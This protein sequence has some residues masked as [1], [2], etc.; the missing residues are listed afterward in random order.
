MSVITAPAN[1][2]G[3]GL[4]NINLAAGTADMSGH[5]HRRAEWRERDGCAARDELERQLVELELC[6]RGVHLQLEHL[7]QRHVLAVRREG[8]RMGRG[9][10]ASYGAAISNARRWASSIT[11]RVCADLNVP[12]LGASTITYSNPFS[13]SSAHRT[14]TNDLRNPDSERRLLHRCRSLA[15]DRGATSGSNCNGGQGHPVAVGENGGTLE[16]CRSARSRTRRHERGL[17]N[18]PPSQARSGTQAW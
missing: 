6:A 13:A 5:V 18:C 16:P 8:R 14:T 15:Q 4:A 12:G 17:R 3:F 9:S 1:T 11:K 10:Q 7:H 2:S